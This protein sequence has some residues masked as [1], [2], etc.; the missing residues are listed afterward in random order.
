MKQLLSRLT[1]LEKIAVAFL[2]AVLVV[3]G[4]QVLYA[5][6]T[7]H[8]ETS[9]TEGGIYV[10]GAYGKIEAIN[11]LFMHYGSVTH[12]LTKLIFSGL[13]QYDPKTQE[14]VPDLADFKVSND[15]KTYTFVLKDNATWHDGKPVTADDVVFTYQTVIQ[16]PAFKGLI[17]NTNDFRGMKVFK[18]DNR[19]VKFALEKPDSFFLVKTIIG[20][21][22]E[23]LLG[24]IPVEGLG[25]DP[26][27]QAPIGSGPYRFVSLTPTE[28]STEVT[29]Q[30]YLDYYGTKPNIP[31]LQI[32]VFSTPEE[33]LNSQSDLDGIRV[34]PDDKTEKVLKGKHLNLIR[35]YLPQYVA[36]FINTESPIL[37]TRNV[38]LALQLGTDKSVIAEVLN[39]TRIIDTPLLEINQNNW[40]Y[41][42]SVSKANGSL[43][44][45]E[46]QLPVKPEAEKSSTESKPVEKDPNDT[47]EVKFIN[48][49]NGGKD[50]ETTDTKITLTGTV[51]P[52][53]KGVWVDDY[54]L[55]KFVPGDPM[56][57]Y[58]AS[59]EYGNLKKGKNVFQVYA[60][61]YT[62]KK[63]LI[64]A[65]T[66]TQGRAMEFDEKE[67]EKIKQE[68][69]EAKALPTRIN[70]K[71]EELL[72]NLIV[73]EQPE[74]YG[75]IAG[76][77]AEQWKKIGINVFIQVLPADTFQQRLLKRD[78]DLLIFGQSLGYNLDAYPY[79]H[80]SQAREGGLNL[81][82]FRNFAVDSLLEKARL[83]QTLD[84]R[85]KTLAEIQR[86]MSY[87]VPAVFLYSPMYTTALTD[88]IQNAAFENL[89]TVSDR[90]ARIADW[91][92]KY[93]RHWAKGTSPLTFFSWVL[94]QF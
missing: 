77:L 5:F 47:S 73:P 25:Y 8:T 31:V 80:S 67:L 75:K 56:W 84:Q 13:A 7:E 9:P 27:S 20:L 48:S 3:T 50:W 76:Q 18:I 21:L 88:K 12:D 61:D 74:A 11:P 59:L 15:G 54:E 39:Q 78:Y 64:D 35:F 68:N 19:T 55:K 62:D 93:D 90:F 34:V 60:V 4:F 6:Y 22:P 53:T 36:V 69:A 81:S 58:V 94:K 72:M 2:T 86:I 44:D 24:H 1:K 71:G 37:K 45:T 52:K 33:V 66:I 28:N 63:S 42:Y 65:I 51:P 40:V 23:H 49:P 89:A 38:R 87:E 83:Q 26:F 79:W 32:R 10:E 70:K 92:A 91:T 85:K 29:L 43:H 30:A 16:D 46:W 14:I 57:S 41:Q 17:L 82:Q